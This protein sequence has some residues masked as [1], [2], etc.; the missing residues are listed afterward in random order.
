M[1]YCCITSHLHVAILHVCVG[2]QPFPFQILWQPKAES[3]SD[4][5]TIIILH[6]WSAWRFILSFSTVSIA[7]ERAQ[8]SFPL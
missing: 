8:T 3:A 6:T 7:L 4:I 1:S 2:T 5:I